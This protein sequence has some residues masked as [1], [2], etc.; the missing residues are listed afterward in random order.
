[1][2]DYNGFFPLIKVIKSKKKK[3]GLTSFYF[4]GQETWL[5]DSTH[6][7]KPIKVL[8]ILSSGKIQKFLTWD[9]LAF[10]TISHLQA[11]LRI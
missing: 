3:M 4:L 10:S 8:Q 9:I 7:N 5:D 2:R 6:L 11:E 1:M